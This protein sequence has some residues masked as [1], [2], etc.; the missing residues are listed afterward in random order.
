M[1]FRLHTL[2]GPLSVEAEHNF[3]ALRIL[4]RP[5][6][7]AVEALPDG[8]YEAVRYSPVADAFISYSAASQTLALNKAFRHARLCEEVLCKEQ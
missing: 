1:N 7:V 3:E 8:R 6:A 4:G 5:D 2:Y